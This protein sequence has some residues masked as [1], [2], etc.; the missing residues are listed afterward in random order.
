MREHLQFLQSFIK[1]PSQVGAIAPSGAELA[2]KMIE[3]IDAN[4]DNVVLEIGIGT[5]AIT[6]H[7]QKLIPNRESYLGIEIEK[8][9]VEKL[10]AEFP[11]L[12]IVCGDA[13]HTRDILSQ[14]DFG[15]VSYIISG[16]PFVVLPE[17]IS[18]GILREVDKLMDEGCMFR[19]FQYFHGYNLPPARR[20]RQR[21]DEQYGKAKRSSLILKNVPPAYTLTWQT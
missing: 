10:H 9:F 20:F 4:K 12:N 14:Q 17:K 7:L 21:L 1:N 16:M 13:C 15:K 18:D 11:K 5:G 2:K 19:T 3:G 6:R 8:S